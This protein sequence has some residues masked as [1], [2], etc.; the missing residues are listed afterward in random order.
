MNTLRGKMIFLT[1]VAALMTLLSGMVGIVGNKLTNSQVEQGIQ[2]TR[3]QS[4]G[5]HDISLAMLAFKNQVQEFKNV[6]IR[7]NDK[8]KFDKHS[9]GFNKES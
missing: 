8:A 9:E 4:A 3:H 2:R 5:Q 1:V 7:G 6:L